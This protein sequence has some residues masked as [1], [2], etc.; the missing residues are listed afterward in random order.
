MLCISYRNDDVDAAFEVCDA[1]CEDDV[2]AEI[3]KMWK[4]P[5]KAIHRQD[6]VDSFGH[7]ARI[8]KNLLKSNKDKYLIYSG[9]VLKWKGED[10]MFSRPQRFH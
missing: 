10:H 2:V 1:V 3:K 5:N 6:I 4:H 8:R 7:I 9:S